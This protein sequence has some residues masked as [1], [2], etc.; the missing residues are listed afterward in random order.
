MATGRPPFDNEDLEQLADSICF[1]DLPLK[2]WFSKDF[3]DLVLRLTNKIPASR[4]GSNNGAAD[5]KSHPFF[6]SI[7]WNTVSEKAMKPPIVPDHQATSK[8]GDTA[9]LA[10]QNPYQVLYHCFDKKFYDQPID[11]YP[12]T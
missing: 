9:S 1:D 6:K 2:T 3:A 12:Q 10:V 7:N 4:L 11:L 5:I 8:S